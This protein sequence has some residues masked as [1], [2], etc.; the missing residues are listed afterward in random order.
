[1]RLLTIQVK[2]ISQSAISIRSVIDSKS[3]QWSPTHLKV[4]GGNNYSLTVF[5]RKLEMKWTNKHEQITQDIR[6]RIGIVRKIHN[7]MNKMKTKKI[8]AE[9]SL[10]SSGSYECITEQRFFTANEQILF[11]YSTTLRS[12]GTPDNGPLVPLLRQESY[13]AAASLC[14]RFRHL[15]LAQSRNAIG[16]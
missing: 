7:V 4:P 10:N 12:G 14:A 5:I 11:F 1:M 13:T 9:S 8:E 15:I 6:W 2:V 16:C 3:S